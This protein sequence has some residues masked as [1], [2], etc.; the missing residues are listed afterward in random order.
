MNASDQLPKCLKIIVTRCLKL[1]P[2]LN[3]ISIIK[4]NSIVTKTLKEQIENSI[5]RPR[6][7][8]SENLLHP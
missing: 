2:Y 1:K 7:C 5:P 4:L 6:H 8:F 3:S